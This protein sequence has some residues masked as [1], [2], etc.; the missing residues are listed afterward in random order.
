MQQNR[1]GKAK[2]ELRNLI[3]D[4]ITGMSVTATY[5][6]TKNYRVQNVD[7]ESTPRS[8][9]KRGNDDVTFVQYYQQQYDITIRDEKQCMLVA[10]VKSNIPGEVSS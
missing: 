7:F 1:E 8:T 9:F 5:G 3:E 4:K 2:G 6:K 10:R